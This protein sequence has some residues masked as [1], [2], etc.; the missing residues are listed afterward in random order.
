MMQRLAL[1]LVALGFWCAP[2]LAANWTVT[3]VNHVT[4]PEPSSGN[5]REMSGVTYVG[6]VG[7]AHRFIAVQQNRENVVRFDVAFTPAGGIASIANVVNIP[8]DDE[9][10]FEGIAY[11]NPTRNS[12]FVSEE[13]NPGVRELSLANGAT[14]QTLTIPAVFANLR[15]NK[16]FESLTRTRDA[17]TMWTANEEALTVD[18]PASSS[19]APTVVRMLRLDVAGDSVTT[20]PQYAYQVAPIHGTGSGSRSG[21]CDLV[22]MPDGTV[23]SLERSAAV[24]LPAFLNRIYELD[25]AGA[26]DVGQGATAGG[27][28]G[29]TYTPVSKQL[30]WSGSVDGGIGQNFEGLG[31]GPRLANGKWTLI[32]V[33]DA[34]NDAGNTVVAFTAT[35]NASADFNLDGHVDGA[36]FLAWQRGVGK[37]VGAKLSEGDADRD[38]DVDAEDLNVWR[39]QQPAPPAAA[40]PEPATGAMLVPGLLL[41]RAFQRPC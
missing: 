12:V 20:G 38:G 21:L 11:T 39:G 22:A 14:L 6:P 26:T 16:G 37:S 24:T 29:K 5:V 10:D 28:A 41:L 18:G 15:D 34:G 17:T 2:T 7:D 4:L 27:L 13:N 23:L 40:A 25:F 31:L 19:T 1:A 32:G 35:A 3:R 30:L 9:L 33:V 8:I 36:D